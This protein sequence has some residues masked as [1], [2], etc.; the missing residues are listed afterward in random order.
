[1]PT[2]KLDQNGIVSLSPSPEVNEVEIGIDTGG[3]FTDAAAVRRSGN[4]EIHV[5]ATA[6]ALTTKAN[7]AVGVTN[8]LEAVLTQIRATAN[9]PVVTL[10]SVSTT[11]ATNAVVEGHG[12]R[13]AVVLVGFDDAMVARLGVE[14]SFSDCLVIRINGGHDH[15]GNE[16]APVD[17]SELGTQLERLTDSV[18]AIAVCSLF[19]VRNPEH[20]IRAAEFIS[21]HTGLPVTLSS[22]LTGALDATRRAITAILNAR[23]VSRI[24]ALV[25]A[26]E[27]A[28]ANLHLQCPIL[29]VKGDG[30]RTSSTSVRL[31]P[32][33]T[34]MSGPAAS[35]IGAAAMSGLSDCI[36]SDVGGTTTDIAVLKNGRPLL[37]TD[38]ARV[39][40]W[41]TLVRAAD[42]R[43]HGLG[44]DSEVHQTP[45]LITVGPRR[46]VPVSLLATRFPQIIKVM[47]ADLA[48]STTSNAGQGR[49]VALPFGGDDTQCNTPTE[50]LNAQEAG[51]IAR[52]A[53]GPQ[54]YRAIAVTSRLQRTIHDLQLRGVL[55]ISALSVSDAA[56]VVGT[57]TTWSVE[58]A[59]LATQLMARVRNMRIPI[60]EDAQ[61]LAR[62][63]LDSAITQSGVAIFESALGND[64]DTLTSN[65]Y[66]LLRSVAGGRTT[67]GLVSLSASLA[68]PIVAVGG[69]APLL[70]PELGRRLGTDVVLLEH[71]AVANAIGAALG[72]VSVEVTINVEHTESSFR[73]VSPFGAS[74]HADL[75]TSISAARELAEERALELCTERGGGRIT[76]T[77]TEERVYLPGRTDDNGLLTATITCSATGLPQAR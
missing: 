14:K 71:G 77:M 57:Q 58:A 11:L 41:S 3:T 22:E 40:G 4:G 46:V 54:P 25:A 65:D 24:T 31:R 75:P 33:E 18:K 27:R 49:F 7:L 47:E 34:V 5:I 59:T 74:T 48:D 8:A 73:V 12:D 67:R 61:Q 62:E 42:I 19:A 16:R 60:P 39:G 29:F 28:S 76:T 30:T 35:T 1:L 69:P 43:T 36:M 72:P 10:L 26:V 45:T 9:Q 63:I 68:I 38:G 17:M 50:H 55:T 51:I 44:G 56:H 13:V 6:K 2:T 23:L 32:I 37:R 52:L 15:T 64:T 53:K 66:D 70:Y 21:A 20:E